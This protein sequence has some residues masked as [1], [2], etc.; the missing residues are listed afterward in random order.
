MVGYVVEGGISV[1]TKTVY[2]VGGILQILYNICFHTYM[3]G[4][5][6]HT[7]VMFVVEKSR[8]CY[9]SNSNYSSYW[10]MYEEHLSQ[11]DKWWFCLPV[12][13][14][15]ISW[16]LS[17]QVMLPSKRPPHNNLYIF[18]F[19]YCYIYLGKKF[20][21]KQAIHI[22]LSVISSWTF[23][24][25]DFHSLILYWLLLSRQVQVY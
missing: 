8:W 14:I 16:V 6:L 25:R 1:I 9:S 2:Y 17:Q 23:Y 18:H 21:P 12:M 7:Y 15:L 22:V 10:I 20:T 19:Y 11:W 5:I 3:L 13:L 24:P 4:Q